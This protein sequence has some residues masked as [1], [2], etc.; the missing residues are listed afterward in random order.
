[1]ELARATVK[2]VMEN[3]SQTSVLEL[4]RDSVVY[5]PV[6]V[7]QLVMVNFSIQKLLVYASAHGILVLF[8]SASS[9]DSVAKPF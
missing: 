6:Q 8:T 1:M 3:I 2:V 9:Q 7:F 4:L 5:Q